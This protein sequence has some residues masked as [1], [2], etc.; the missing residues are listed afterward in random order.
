[1]LCESVYGDNF[2][3]FY[4]ILLQDSSIEHTKLTLNDKDNVGPNH[5]SMTTVLKGRCL[6][7]ITN[8]YDP[9]EAVISLGLCA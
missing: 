2:D 4:S 5:F 1:M 9:G 7:D 6:L 3:R 8:T